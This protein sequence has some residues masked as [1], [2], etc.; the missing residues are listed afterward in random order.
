MNKIERIY[1]YVDEYE[2]FICDDIS[3]LV[4]VIVDIQS[5]RGYKNPKDLWHCVV[6]LINKDEI[7]LT[8]NLLINILTDK[9]V[10]RLDTRLRIISEFLEDIVYK[11]MSYYGE[12]E[13]VS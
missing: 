12:G 11:V 6:E 13:K 2:K 7:I 8:E 5:L 4:D 9:R 10:T 3:T 1:Y